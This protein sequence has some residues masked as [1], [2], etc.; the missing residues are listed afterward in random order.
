MSGKNEKYPF[1]VKKDLP[2]AN[3]LTEKYTSIEHDLSSLEKYHF[4]I[5]RNK[6]WNTID[7]KLTQLP[8][9]QSWHELGLFQKRDSGNNPVAEI[10]VKIIK[11]KNE[12]SPAKVLEKML[13]ETYQDK[14]LEILN[15]QT[16]DSSQGLVKDVLFKYF[17]ENV[18]FVSRMTVF[19]TGR[20]MVLIQ[21]NASEK[22]YNVFA[23]DFYMAISSF[24]F[25]K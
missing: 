9:V 21:G 8:T 1:I 16:F 22:D 10:V 19:S 20:E 5:A 17:Y 6:D 7:I 2:S 14:N 11:I 12:I 18:N 15:Q 3:Q 13:E 24:N 25:V 4:K 23:L